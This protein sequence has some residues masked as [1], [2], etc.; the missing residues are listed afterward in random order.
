M[1]IT[2]T[3]PKSAL[4][5]KYVLSA[6]EIMAISNNIGQIGIWLICPHLGNDHMDICDFSLF[7]NCKYLQKWCS[8]TV[9]ID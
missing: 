7:I 4:T 6:S 2:T 5:N 9:I 3:L 8:V 1:G